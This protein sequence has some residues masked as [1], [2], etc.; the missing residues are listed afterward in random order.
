M[1][2]YIVDPLNEGVL[3]P[4]NGPAANAHQAKYKVSGHVHSFFIQFAKSPKQS[5]FNPVGP[6]HLVPKSN[7][8]IEAKARQSHMSGAG[9]FQAVYILGKLESVGSVSSAIPKPAMLLAEKAEKVLDQDNVTTTTKSKAAAD[10][11]KCCHCHRMYGVQGIKNHEAACAKNTGAYGWGKPTP[12]VGR[13][14]GED[15]DFFDGVPEDDQLGAELGGDRHAD[16]LRVFKSKKAKKGKKEKK[17]KK[18]K[19]SSSSSND[20]TSSP[21]KRSVSE[22]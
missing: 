6:W 5:K 2:R 1:C 20:E 21:P 3:L 8:K 7:S 22:I 10:K 15:E 14:E 19:E 9:V 12:K 11:A 16:Y 17:K 18:K 4:T 13:D